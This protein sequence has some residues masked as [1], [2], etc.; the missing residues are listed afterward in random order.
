MVSRT[1]LAEGGVALQAAKEIKP[2]EDD[3][4]AGLPQ[5][6]FVMAGGGILPEAWMK[7]LMTVS[8]RM[9]KMYP[10]GAEL[11]DEQ[12]GK[13]AELSTKLMQGLHSMAMVLGV[14]RAGVP[15]Y[16]DTVMLMKVDNA[17]EYLDQY[18]RV[19]GEMSELGKASQSV[20]FS[21]RVEKT[22]ID[23]TPGLKVTM[24]LAA[25]L[26]P[27]QPPEAK[28]V[29]ELML[30]DQKELPIYLA[31]ANPHLVVG[32]Y[33]SQERLMKAHKVGESGRR[34]DVRRRERQEDR[35]YAA[36]RVQWVELGS[37]RGTLQ[38]VGRMMPQ[39]GAQPADR[40][41]GVPGDVADRLRHE[42]DTRRPGDG[43]SHP[44]RCAAGH[45]RSHQEELAASSRRAAC[46]CEQVGVSPANGQER[47]LR[48]E[49]AGTFRR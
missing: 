25:F 20:L 26:P 34:S 18:S 47:R 14:G 45:G 15:L 29:M 38:F 23:G 28:K 17:Q 2:T 5:G 33:I 10:G 42:A 4:L 11:T 46:G 37:P 9:M 21:Y 48:K 39:D 40:D 16:G 49:G 24:N 31:A 32:A 27:G 12:A 44:D 19:I 30:G 6:P 13:L 1:L 8:V 7:R 22:P 3:L 36:G 41:S 43:S 35:G